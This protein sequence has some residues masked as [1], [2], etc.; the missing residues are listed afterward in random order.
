MIVRIVRLFGLA[1]FGASLAFL[2]WWWTNVA[3]HDEAGGGVAAAAVNVLLF[4]VFALHHSIMARPVPQRALLRLVRPELVR[5]VYVYTASV[6]LAVTCAWWQPVGAT[7]YRVQGSA[8]VLL[9]LVQASGVMLVVAAAWRIR[10]PELAGVADPDPGEALQHGGAY[11]IVRHPIYLGWILFF[12]AAPHMT[13]DRLLFAAI[14]SAYLVLA[15]PFEEAGLRRQ[16]GGRYDAYRQHVRWRV[17][18]FV[19]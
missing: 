2:G 16:F 5:T 12:G 14:S 17:L 1:A 15:V 11:G 8:A 7:V 18:P 4:S 19:Y 6:L 3:G 10:V 13:A 9:R